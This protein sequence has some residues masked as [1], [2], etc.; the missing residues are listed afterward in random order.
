V[1][2]ADALSARDHVLLAEDGGM[3]TAAGEEFLLGF[4]IDLRPPN[5]RHRAFC[6]PC[7]DWSE[8]RPHLAGWIERE[9]DSRAVSITPEGER[10]LSDMFG[11]I[12]AH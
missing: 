9:R 10:G 1:A 2:L 6:R 12:L 8:R 4:G 3:V 5:R 7:L 11:I